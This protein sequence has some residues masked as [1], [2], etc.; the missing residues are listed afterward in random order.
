MFLFSAGSSPINC[1]ILPCQ[2]W[3]LE[4]HGRAQRGSPPG[5]AKMCRHTK[6]CDDWSN[7]W[8]DMVICRFFKMAAAAVLDF[9]IFKIWRVGRI[10]R[11]KVRRHA[12]FHGDQSS[13]CWDMAIFQDGGR[14][15]VGFLKCRNFRFRRVKR[16]NMHHRAKF[17]GDR[18]HRCWDM[19]M[20][21]SPRN[22]AFWRSLTLLTLPT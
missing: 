7:C 10:K 8:W 16:I 9:Y 5:L 18:S 21:R 12:K 13:R 3:Y 20:E 1:L 17:R 2:M 14:R 4:V 19:A 11:L 6:F 15:H 22:L